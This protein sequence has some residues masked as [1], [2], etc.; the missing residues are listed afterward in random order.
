[1]RTGQGYSEGWL[2][3][4]TGSEDVGEMFRD[5]HPCARDQRMQEC[6]SEPYKLGERLEW[7]IPEATHGH[8]LGLWGYLAV[9]PK[10]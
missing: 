4:D 9:S 7:N 2:V 8:C 5:W 10:M 1:M 3:V 6:D